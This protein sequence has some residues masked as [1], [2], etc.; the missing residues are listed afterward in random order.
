MTLSHPLA[1]LAACLMVLSGC[2]PGPRSAT[3]ALPL[4]ADPATTQL[5]Q[6][7]DAFDTLSPPEKV[8]APRAAQAMPVAP[9]QPPLLT[10]LGFAQIKG[11]PGKTPN[12]KRLMAIRAARLEALRD[13]TEQVHGIHI[14]AETTLRDAIVQNDRLTGVVE[15]TIRGARTLRITPRDADSYEVLMALDRDTVGYILRAA[16]GLHNGGF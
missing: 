6:M 8:I 15:G 12:E 11:Q 9:D 4:G 5:A 2:M 3:A 7:K 10:G 13:L 14:D 16:R 1:T